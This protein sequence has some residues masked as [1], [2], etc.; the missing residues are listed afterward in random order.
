MEPKL[1]RMLMGTLSQPATWMLSVKMA[2]K[3]LL[4]SVSFMFSLEHPSKI[5]CHA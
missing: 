4:V 2:M 5:S 3:E 1:L